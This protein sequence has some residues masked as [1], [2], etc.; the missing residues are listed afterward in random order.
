MF[1]ININVIIKTNH[2]NTVLV[3][4]VCCGIDMYVKPVFQDKERVMVNLYSAILFITCLWIVI[5]SNII[6]ID[7]LNNNILIIINSGV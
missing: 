1:P 7:Q 4:V 6:N 2:I 5:Q 3:Y